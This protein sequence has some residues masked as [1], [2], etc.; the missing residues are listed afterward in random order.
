MDLTAIFLLLRHT[1]Y[2]PQAGRTTS[3]PRMKHSYALGALCALSF[4]LISPDTQAQRRKND[5]E[6]GEMVKGKKVGVWEYFSLTRD[7]RQVL[8]QR[9]D[10]TAN[11]LLFYRPIEDVPYET[12]VQ[13]GQ[14]T[15]T[16]VQQPPLFIG[17]E[18][19]LAAYMARLNYPQQAQSRNIQGR[20]LVSFAIDTL[21]RA[22]S[23]K[24]LMGIGGG[25][26]EEALRLSR[27]IPAQWIPARLN[28]RAV[29]VVY[30]L[31]FTFRLQ[32]PR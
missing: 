6:A 13:P 22:T 26:D 28:G 23:H 11:K 14:W 31:P 4:L 3:H 20:V 17:G 30:E 19:A 12:E 15:R 24:V 5:L 27:T 7:G 21:G 16:R 25:C 10:H 32:T 18:A 9:Y 29:P 2:S 8:V 1:A